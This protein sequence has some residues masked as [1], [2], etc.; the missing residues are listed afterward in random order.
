MKSFCFVKTTTGKLQ[1]LG[2][3]YPLH[4]SCAHCQHFC[5]GFAF[6]FSLHTHKDTQVFILLCIILTMIIMFSW[7]CY[8]DLTPH[9]QI[10]HQD[11]PKKGQILL[12]THNAV[13]KLRKL[14]FN[15]NYYP[16]YSWYSNFLNCPNAAWKYYFPLSSRV[17]SRIM[18]YI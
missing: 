8:G 3:Q 12:Y 10:L 9:P 14:K 15:T 4:L 5:H 18:H 17:Q 7:I 1:E 13:T 11:S 16:I 2:S 6:S